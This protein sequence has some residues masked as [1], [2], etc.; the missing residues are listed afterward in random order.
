MPGFKSIACDKCGARYEYI[1]NFCAEC[2]EAIHDRMHPRV[3]ARVDEKMHA[4]TSGLAIASFVCSLCGI[5]FCLISVVGLVLGIIALVQIKNDPYKRGKG[6][7]I[8]GVIISSIMVAILLFYTALIIV[9]AA[10]SGP[11]M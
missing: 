9:F 1:P 5:P 10:S 4:S 8:A 11:G 2:G 3:R 6:F 7:A